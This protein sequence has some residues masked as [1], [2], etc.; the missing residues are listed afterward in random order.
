MNPRA[1]ILLVDDQAGNLEVLETILASPDLELVRAHSA[2]EALLALLGQE[3]A[4]I[5][6]DIRMPRMSGIELAQIIKQR[7]RT[8]H[9]PI[10]FLTAEGSDLA[11]LVLQEAAIESCCLLGRQRRAQ[12]GLDLSRS[13]GL[14]HDRHRHARDAQAGLSRVPAA[15]DDGAVTVGNRIPG[16]RPPGRR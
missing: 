7:K 13:G 2:E 3:F 10:L 9:V 6:L 16:P 12:P 5:V 14:G 11:D 4:A 15:G 1:R 8:Q